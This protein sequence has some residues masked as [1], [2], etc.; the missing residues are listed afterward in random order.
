[1]PR[2]RKD[3]RPAQPALRV[4]K[5]RVTD[6]GRTWRLRAYG[7]TPENPHGRVVRL[8]PGTGR[9]TSNV[10]VDGQSLD[11]LFDQ[12]ERW[13]DQSVSL[14][15]CPSTTGSGRRDINAL[16]DLYLAE[17]AAKG[18]DD[19]YIAGRR[20]I[21]NKWVLPRIGEVLVRGWSPEH[22]DA[23]ITPAR[24]AVSPARV[25]DIGSTLSG[26]RATAH[27]KR[28]GGR[29]LALDENP[30]E[31]VEYTR[32]ATREKTNRNYVPPSKR[33]ATGMVEKAI[34]A[35]RELGRWPWL[36][37][38]ISVS[39]FCAPRQ[40]ELLGLRAVDVDLVERELDINGVWCTPPS[41][42]RAGQGKTRSGH[43]KPHPKNKLGRTT[44]YRGSQHDMLRQRC[45][46]A[47]GL[48]PDTDEQTVV[49]RIE[50]ERAR[51]AAKTGDYRDA[52]VPPQDELWLFPGEDGVPP[53]KE[54]FNDAWHV[55]RDAVGWPTYIPYRNLRH[56][57]ALW[58]RDQGLDWEQI[59]EY[60]GHDV[61][62][63]MAF[64]VRPADDGRVK[65][66]GLLDAT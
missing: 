30:L 51:R 1:M 28:P 27:R 38:A 22:N 50:A 19:A 25:E 59:A 16:A 3:G 7:P 42:Q 58:W 11:D 57:A 65:A 23:V 54:Q 32:R 64:Y 8:V 62:T 40:A 2:P 45:A 46:V 21:L 49:E 53:T 55:V 24:S 60:D 48:D 14:D 36:S 44:P 63:L 26:L 18:R 37:D 20:S 34:I 10:P 5:E 47:L 43:R 12:T 41:G 52:K 31:G 4:G 56:H 13:L 35:A 29:W 15:A 6:G 33:P 39:G 9:P 17:L 61:R 66:R